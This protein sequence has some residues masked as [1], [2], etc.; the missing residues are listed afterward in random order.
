M[1]HLDQL[2]EWCS[3]SKATEQ[4][5]RLYVPLD[6][7]YAVLIVEGQEDSNLY[8]DAFNKV[9][10][11]KDTRVIICNGKGGV[12]GLRNFANVNYADASKLMF[13]IDRVH[14]DFIGLSMEDERTYV[15]DNYSIEWDACTEEVLFALVARHYALST[16][17]PVWEKV[18]EKFHKLMACWNSHARPIMYAMILA[19]RAGQQLELESIYLSDICRLNGSTY[20]PTGAELGVL[21]EK[22]GSRH[23]PSGE[24]L[25]QCE[26]DLSKYDIR[27]YVRGKLAVYF[28]CEFF[29]KIGEICDSPEKI[30]G[31]GLVT[32]VQTGKSIF[33]QFIRDDWVIPESLRNIFL[34]WNDRQATTL[35]PKAD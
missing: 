30:D 31:Q 10:D 19:R 24:D 1:T 11:G 9:M 23:C 12:L 3:A 4:K 2:R 6:E 33:F 8:T 13:F 28:F 20:E 15:T 35:S 7:I 26:Y 21:L 27:A 34:S 5:L 18:K 14:D 17:D 32:G 25:A 16:Y 22:A 29:Q